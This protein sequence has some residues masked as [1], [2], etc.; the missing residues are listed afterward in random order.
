TTILEGNPSAVEGL[1]AS[2]VNTM[3]ARRGDTAV[4]FLPEG[5]AYVMVE[6]ST[7]TLDA[8]KQQCQDL[9]S[10]LHKNKR[11]RDYVIVT[12]AADRAKIWKVRED[13]A[14]LSSTQIDGTQTWPG[15]EDAAV[16]PEKL[17]DYL[18]DLIPLIEQYNYSASMY[19]H[20]GAGC[21]HMRLDFDF[22]TK[23]GRE[24]FT[25]FM[26]EAAK[27]VISHGGSLSGEHGDGRA[28]SSLLELMYSEHILTLFHK[29]KR[30]WDPQNLLNPGII[31]DPV[32]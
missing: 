24:D 6:F 26:H 16:A 7:D 28:R 14:G 8:A 27:I 19:G 31:V 18:T 11:I 30:I 22:R 4:K 9:L 20:F 3:R 25:S 13:G 2:I 23:Q 32:K 29:F 17:A 12:D 5:T 15:W 10:R 1:D 21:V